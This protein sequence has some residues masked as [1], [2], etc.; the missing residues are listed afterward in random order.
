MSAANNADQAHAK[1]AE[2]ASTLKDSAVQQINS[3]ELAADRT[4][5]VAEGIPYA[6]QGRLS[7]IP[8]RSGSPLTSSHICECVGF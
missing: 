2:S 3:T 7:W 5:R 6:T 8:R 1:L 4:G